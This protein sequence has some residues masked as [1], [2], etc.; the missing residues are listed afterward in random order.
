MDFGFCFAGGGLLGRVAGGIGLAGDE[1]D[2]APR[3]LD[4]LARRGADAVDLERERLG[5]GAVAEHLDAL[6]GAVDEA[7]LAQHL[8]VD[9]AADGEFLERLEIDRRIADL[10]RGVIEAALG[11]AADEGHLAAFEAEPDAAAGAGLLA[12][13]AL[14]AGLAVA[15][16]F[17]AAEALDAMAR[18]G[19]GL[20]GVES[21]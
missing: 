5:E 19:T 13:V 2:G 16:A 10:E 17:A 14:A 6:P 21:K 1:L 11:Q 15:G 8:L 18:T 3:L 9:H 7:G 4:L 12:F 20:E